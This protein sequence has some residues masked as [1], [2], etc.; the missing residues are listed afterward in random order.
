M[1]FDGRPSVANQQKRMFRE[2]IEKFVTSVKGSSHTDITGGIVQAIEF[3]T[4]SGAGHRHILIFSD[5]EE[6][7]AQGQ[8]RDFPLEM[9]GCNVAA[10]NVTK[11]RSD[12]I[13]PRDYYQRV[14]Q[15]ERRVQEGG[16]TWKM[17]N[18][19]ENLENLLN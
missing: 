9:A 17:V 2:E 8:I 19:L 12:N 16:G 4:E 1:T 10:L 3:L 18:D 15:W 6:D 13:D 5:L 11:L 7:L 14:D